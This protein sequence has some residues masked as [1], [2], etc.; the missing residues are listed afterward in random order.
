M[1][2]RSSHWTN[3]HFTAGQ[4]QAVTSSRGSNC[5]VLPRSAPGLRSS[6]KESCTCA[7]GCPPRPG[8]LLQSSPG[9]Q[10]GPFTPRRS[11]QG[12]D[13]A[14]ARGARLGP[15]ISRWILIHCTTEE[16]PI[17]CLFDSIHSSG[18]EVVTHCGFSRISLMPNDID[19]FSCAYWPLVYL[20]RGNVHSDPVFIL[21]L[22]CLFIIEL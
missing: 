10:P 6:M 15:C 9:K 14:A 4:L 16:V 21:K 2:V 22:G 1:Y 5:K 18:C 17:I 19:I 8:F 12:S 20:L 3:K 7:R 11:R 13:A